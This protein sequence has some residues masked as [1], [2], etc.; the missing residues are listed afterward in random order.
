MD[1]CSEHFASLLNGTENGSKG[2]GEPD[3]P[4]DINETDVSLFEVG[5]AI[6]CL[7]NN[8]AEGP[9]ELIKYGS[10]ERTRCMQQ[11]LCRI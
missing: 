1:L 5:K 11:I 9:S 7:E 3:F 2:V 10:E 6:A 8:K 4:I